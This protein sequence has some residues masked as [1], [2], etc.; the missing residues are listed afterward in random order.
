VERSPAWVPAKRPTAAG[1]VSELIAAKPVFEK[2]RSSALALFERFI[3]H[4]ITN[5]ALTD[6]MFAGKMQWQGCQAPT[7]EALFSLWPQR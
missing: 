6:K 2:Q 4:A 5:A 7:L 3:N 1:F